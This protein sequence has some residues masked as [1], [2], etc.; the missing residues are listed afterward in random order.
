MLARY[1]RQPQRQVRYQLHQPAVPA[2]SNYQALLTRG[3][4]APLTA[5]MAGQ[6]HQ[7]PVLHGLLQAILHEH[8]PNSLGPFLDYHQDLTGYDP[9]TTQPA[10]PSEHLANVLHDVFQATQ[11]SGVPLEHLMQAFGYDR[12]QPHPR[13]GS[14]GGPLDDPLQ[15][16]MLA[17]RGLLHRPF[18][19]VT[20]L[21][22]RMRLAAE[23]AS[24]PYEYRQE[25]PL[26]Q[27]AAQLVHARHAAT[28]GIPQ[29][30]TDWHDLL[31]QLQ[32]QDAPLHPA[33]RDAATRARERLSQAIMRLVVPVLHGA[34]L[35]PHFPYFPGGIVP[36]E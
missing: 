6:M 8:D 1:L 34:Q 30:Y 28:R 27:I 35:E 20:N 26:Y 31:Q 21:F 29:G 13:L 24:N 17:H 22:D 32:S 25:S 11:G 3:L 7:H 18:N 36:P 15:G 4:D 10:T 9:R 23:Q 14:S 12:S 19:F 5:G 2:L 16:H 33:I